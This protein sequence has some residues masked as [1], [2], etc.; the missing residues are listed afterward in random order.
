MLAEK[1]VSFNIFHLL[2]F[3]YLCTIL[4][5]VAFI[6]TNICWK[7]DVSFNFF[8]FTEMFFALL[9]YAYWPLS[10]AGTVHTCFIALVLPNCNGRYISDKSSEFLESV[11]SAVEICVVQGLFTQSVGS[12]GHLWLWKRP[13]HALKQRQT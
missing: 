5:Q 8:L 6:V 9:H 2:V 7:K 3:I 11:V 1:D 13:Q 12:T 4:H 10:C